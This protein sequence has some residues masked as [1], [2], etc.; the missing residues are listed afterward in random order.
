MASKDADGGGEKKAVRVCMIHERISGNDGTAIVGA[1]LRETDG[2]EEKHL[3][4]VLPLDTQVQH[5]DCF[6][7]M[8]GRGC[9]QQGHSIRAKR[10]A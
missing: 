10:R 6:R 8:R 9:R 7:E 5:A 1:I 3:L 2:Q 4:V